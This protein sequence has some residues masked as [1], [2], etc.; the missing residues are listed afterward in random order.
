[1]PVEPSHKATSF[2]GGASR[3]SA[4]LAVAALALVTTG[5]AGCE[6]LTAGPTQTREQDQTYQ[7]SVSQIEFAVA[8]GKVSLVPGPDGAVVVHRRLKWDKAE[9]VVS[10]A[11]NG[12]TLRVTAT[13]PDG[14]SCS[15]DFTVQ[16]PASVA[17]QLNDNVGDISL[18]DLTGPVNVTLG[19]G[20]VDLTGLS[21]RVRVASHT[22]R[23]SGNALQ[24]TDVDV[25]D[26]T[27]DVAVD[28]AKVPDKV[29]AVTGTG[30]VHVTVPRDTTGY[31]VQAQTTTGKTAVDVPQETSSARSIVAKTATG[32]VRVD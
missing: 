2:L 18:R 6:D 1:M 31:R 12:D 24:S 30:A 28:F 15:V 32:D 20:D 13:C 17:V 27:G 9:P 29:Q 7:H 26:A 11:W 10:E 16:V 21:G 25:T 5:A 19:T 22:G 4:A 3:R 23:I 8:S 14:E